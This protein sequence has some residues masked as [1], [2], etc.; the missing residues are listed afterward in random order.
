MSDQNKRILYVEDNRQNMRLVKKFLRMGGYDMIGADTGEG[1]IEAAHKEIPDL[2]LMDINL[3]DID[4]IEATQRLKAD[5]ETAAIP[6]IAL[7][8]NA[9]HGDRERF[10]E[11]GC[12]GYLS[13]PVSKGDLLEKIAE[14][15]EQAATTADAS[16][17]S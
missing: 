8:A 12:D 2:I 17:A 10:L 13:K 3:P 1:G 15:L 5:E 14:L 4:G 6:I 9:M 11:A 7:T 16:D